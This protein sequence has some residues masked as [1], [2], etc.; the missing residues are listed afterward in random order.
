MEKKKNNNKPICEIC[1]KAI[2][3]NEDSFMI[4]V[5]ERLG[6]SSYSMLIC[7]GCHDRMLDYQLEGQLE[8]QGDYNED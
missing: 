6:D 7:F 5:A 2:D 4:R 3:E 8:A 1:N